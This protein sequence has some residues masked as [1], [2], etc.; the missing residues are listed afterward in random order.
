MDP[1]DD[2]I[3]T[4]TATVWFEDGIIINR[5]EGVA[6]TPE[7]VAEAFGVYH[8]LTEGTPHP[9]L[10]DARKWP[11]GDPDAWAAAITK[12]EST[13][14]AIAML[15]GPDSPAYTGTFPPIIDRLL[16]PFRIF[17]DEAEALAFLHSYRP[18]PNA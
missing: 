8:D 15:V 16:I 12:F 2:A 13:V 11:G 18:E 10:F 9:L 7:S 14:N 5:A 4:I 6:S 1:P 17:T 3:E